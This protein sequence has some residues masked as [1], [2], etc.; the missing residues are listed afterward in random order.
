MCVL[1]K[2]FVNFASLVCHLVHQDD[3]ELD[4]DMAF[5]GEKET[6][7]LWFPSKIL[8]SAL[9]PLQMVSSFPIFT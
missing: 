4:Y 6:P 3:V 9:W 2:L 7:I 1:N 8:F 5:A